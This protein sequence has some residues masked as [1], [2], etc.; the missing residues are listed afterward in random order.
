MFKNH[1]IRCFS[2][3]LVIAFALGGC[4]A[5]PRQAKQPD[6]SDS[7]GTLVLTDP[8][9]PAESPDPYQPE[10]PSADD[11]LA[12]ASRAN[13]PVMKEEEEASAPAQ[14]SSPELEEES[15]APSQPASPEVEASAAA[16]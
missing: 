14:P 13:D 12:L 6:A 10:A 3:I 16:A 4:N 11:L 15:S 2:V 5:P 8:F 7:S 1:L 9:S